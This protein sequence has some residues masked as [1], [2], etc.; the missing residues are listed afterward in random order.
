MTRL[1]GCVEIVDVRLEEGKVHVGFAAPLDDLLQNN[2]ENRSL[3]PSVSLV[4]AALRR[5]VVHSSLPRITSGSEIWRS[6]RGE[7][8]KIHGVLR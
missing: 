1:Q 2:K 3:I 7:R 6:K 8:R 4:A 5:H